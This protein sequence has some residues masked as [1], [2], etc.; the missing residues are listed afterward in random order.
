MECMEK[1]TCVHGVLEDMC[2]RVHRLKSKHV[3]GIILE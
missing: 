2:A 3:R 1:H